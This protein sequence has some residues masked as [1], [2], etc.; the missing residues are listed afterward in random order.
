MAVTEIIQFETG[1]PVNND[2]IQ[3]AFKNLQEVKT[4]KQFVIGTHV[5]DKSAVQIT[6]EWDDDEG[7]KSISERTPFTNSLRSCLGKPTNIFHIPF[8]TDSTFSTSGPATSN[9]IEYV[10]I[11]FP[12]S[13]INPYFQRKIEQDFVKFDEIFNRAGSHEGQG[14]LA[15]GWVQEEQTHADIPG[16]KAKCFLVTRGWEAMSGFE[17]SVQTEAYKEAVPTLLAW[18]APFKMVSLSSRRCCL[19]SWWLICDAVACS[20][21]LKVEV[22][23]E[24][25]YTDRFLI[26]NNTA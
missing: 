3:N 4:P 11:W 24:L 15:Y 25:A 17:Q 1:S 26:T 6:A 18:E 19:D 20:A 10:Q 2:T 22:T 21:Y 14:S 5:Q 8:N 23:L 12:V 7:S 16:E 9:I 13:R